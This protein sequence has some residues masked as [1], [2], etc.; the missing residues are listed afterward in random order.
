MQSWQQG[1]YSSTT[2]NVCIWWQLPTS[3]TLRT[4]IKCIKQKVK[5]TTCPWRILWYTHGLKVM[6]E[7]GKIK[8]TV[9]GNHKTFT[10]KVQISCEALCI[11]VPYSLLRNHGGKPPVALTG[12]N[13]GWKILPERMGYYSITKWACRFLCE[14]KN[15]DFM[16]V[17]PDFHLVLK[18]E[19]CYKLGWNSQ[20]FFLKE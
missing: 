15:V 4:K 11:K 8:E 17:Q 1:M 3:R 7:S 13:P 2:H 12:F 20:A 10:M 19:P 14:D 16:C 9:Q 5:W 6:W 18:E